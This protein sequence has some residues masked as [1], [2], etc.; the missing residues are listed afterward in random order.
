MLI[1]ADLKQPAF[2]VVPRLCDGNYDA[3]AK[4]SDLSTA[5]YVS[6]SSLSVQ[7]KVDALLLFPATE[8]MKDVGMP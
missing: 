3:A 7:E 6:A 5:H 2:S 1:L 8:Q 4:V